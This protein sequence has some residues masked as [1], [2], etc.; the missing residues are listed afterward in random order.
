MSQQK[1]TDCLPTETFEVD[2][3]DF[4]DELTIIITRDT[5][6]LLHIVN[7]FSLQCRIGNWLFRVALV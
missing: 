5:S 2:C 7:V 4:V 6:I 1:V 3:Q